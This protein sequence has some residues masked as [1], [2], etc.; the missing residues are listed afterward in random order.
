MSIKNLFFVLALTIG[1]SATAQ[2]IVPVGK[3]SYA[4][5]TPLIKSRTNEHGGDQSRYMQSRKLN[6]REREGRP[7]PTNDWW[8]NMLNADDK[9]IGQELTGHLWSYPQYVQ[10][11]KY[12]VDIQQPSFWIA[13]GTEMKSST[14]LRVTG[15]A[16]HPTQA[17]AESWH[18]W[19]VEFSETDGDKRMWVTMVHGMPFTW[20]EMQNISPEI[21]IAKT[22]D[23]QMGNA[24]IRILNAQGNDINGE[25]RLSRMAVMMTDG[26]HTDIYGVYMPEGTL[27]TVEKGVAKM[28]FLGANSY[29]V[30][31]SLHSFDDLT[32]YES[33]AYNVPRE[34]SVAWNYQ[35]GTLNTQWTVTAENLKGGSNTQVMQGFIPH[36]Y[37]DGG[38]PQ[39]SFSGEEWRTP[40]GMLKLATGNTFRIT[41]PFSGMLPYYALPTDTERP[42]NPFQK[43]RM[44]ELLRNYAN[45]GTFGAD[46]YWGGKGLTQMALYMTFAREM[47]ETELFELC[48][49]KLN[50]ALVNWLT[51]SPGED[52][53]F[54]ARDNRWGG[55]IGYDTSYDSDTYNDHHFH[56]GYYTYAAALLALVDDDF[57]KNYGDMMT[58]I[59]KDYA[60]WDKEDTRF[61]FFRTFDPWAGHSFAGGLGDG[62]GNGQ[63]STSEAM[64]SWGGLYLLGVALGN[65]KM[66]DAG[67]FGWVSEARGT[68]EYWFDRHTDPARDMNSFHTA[69][70]ND[71][72]NGYNIDYSKFRKE[73]QQN[74]LYNSNLTCH[75]VGWWT[76][77]SGDPVWMAS[78]QWMPISPALDYLSEDLEFA[79]W[80]YEQT[81]M[82]KEVG[83][84]TADNGLGN[85][86]GLGNVVLSYLQRS[87]PDEAASI[88]DQM[89]DAGKNVARATDTGG[90]TYYVTHSHLTYGEIDWTITADIPTARV[91][92]KDGVKTHMA[93]N[94]T[95]NPITVRFSDGYMLNVPARRLAVEGQTSL[96]NTEIAQEDNTPQDPREQ[97]EMI[98]LALHKPCTA[99][100][101]ENAGTVI[102]NATDG[103]QTT[104]W[105]SN[106]NDGE[107]ISVDLGE[108]AQL[109]K[110]RLH[111]ET[112]FAAEYNILLSDDGVNYHVA[113]SIVSDGGYD[114]IMMDEASARYIKVECV[115]RATQYGIS[116]YEIEAYGKTTT[117]TGNDILGIKLTADADVLK[118]YEESQLMAVGYTCNGEWVSVSPVWNT[119]D[120]TVS[121]NGLF[122]PSVYG[123]ASVTATIGDFM[124]TKA[125]PVEEAIRIG[126]IV[127]SPHSNTVIVGDKKVLEVD[128]YDQFNAP[129]TTHPEGILFGVF[130]VTGD[131]DNRTFSETTMATFEAPTATFK[132]LAKGDYAVVASLGALA[133]TVYISARAI[134]DVNLALNKPAVAT[135]AE[136]DGNSAEKAF[137]GSLGSRWSSAFAGMTND[138]R[139][140]QSL[141]VDLEDAYIINKVVM[142]WENARASKYVLQVSTDGQTWTDVM[143]V[144]DSPLGT[145]TLNFS[146]VEARYVRMQGVD[147]NHTYYAYG[148]SLFEMEVYG[149]GKANVPDGI[150]NVNVNGDVNNNAVYDISGR[151]I[152]GNYALR[153]KHSLQAKRAELGSALPKGIYIYNGKKLAK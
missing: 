11:M 109:Y 135:S 120:G 98:N 143:T 16:F 41:Y 132:A 33:Y 77:F 99:S 114:D 22:G 95:D 100:S 134:E 9:H 19:D 103:D 60:N 136:G 101:H 82:Y 69:T 121:A 80:D 30:V 23:T 14:V 27:V 6:V 145:E 35:Q 117:M 10:G 138:E 93:F 57:K 21:T 34:T 85:E 104:R 116:L 71:Y 45:G 53:Y 97:L 29:V 153:I 39:F 24:T 105:G 133:D 141:T 130:A 111:W 58:L 59:A 47:G 78:I 139:N 66:R 84:F 88:F 63:E 81:M 123:K 137:D 12:G 89:W 18:D 118:Q 32:T 79:R 61:P 152:I 44:M 65:D 144:S 106:H 40:H 5:Y 102:A 92:T 113:K 52:N 2:Q 28:V 15:E 56:Y 150:E 90:I 1:A 42:Q 86:S 72:D 31:A 149:I 26:V 55:M 46:T 7:I 131:D 127:M 64:Q 38:S 151:K 20:I 94:P 91:F 67:I 83:D 49:D 125:F 115:T 62:N 107:W 13:N 17:L 73:D 54:F 96:D 43:E 48:R 126:R 147:R 36:H 25:E 124:V 50:G 112:A 70:G 8:T 3:G 146:P 4:S 129:S 119:T 128:T 148:Y 74:H 76:Y 37:R 51:F 140:D 68:A 122:T 142:V 108:E 110:I 75:G 87:N